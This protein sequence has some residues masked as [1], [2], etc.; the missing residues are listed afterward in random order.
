MLLLKNS[1][2]VSR[3]RETTD[4]DDT[5]IAQGPAGALYTVFGETDVTLRRTGGQRGVIPLTDH[6]PQSKLGPGPHDC[7]CTF[8]DECECRA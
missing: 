6:F 4:F 5:Q 7:I 3:R 8:T 1:F 2:T